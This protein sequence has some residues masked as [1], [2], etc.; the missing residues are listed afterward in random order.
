MVRAII[1]WDTRWPLNTYRDRDPAKM[2]EKALAHIHLAYARLP[3]CE[4]E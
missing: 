3:P 4:E 1:G 2:S